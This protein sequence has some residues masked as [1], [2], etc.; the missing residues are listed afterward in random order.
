MLYRFFYLNFVNSKLL[1]T[2]GK[3]IE[4]RVRRGLISFPQSVDFDGPATSLVL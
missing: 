4:A 1:Q 3:L 2:N